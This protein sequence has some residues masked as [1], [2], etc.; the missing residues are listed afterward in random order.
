MVGIIELLEDFK[1]S[2]QYEKKLKRV[3]EKALL[4]PENLFI[5]VRL[6]DLLTKLRKKKE[7]VGLYE[8]AAQQFIQKNLFAHAIAL[9]KIIFRLEPPKDDGE[10]MTILTRLYEQMLIYR[11]TT[12]VA[13]EATPSQT[14]SSSP[15]PCETRR[16]GLQLEPKAMSPSAS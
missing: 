5:Q 10:K 3:Q 1:V 14:P 15:Q 12:S 2:W 13:E 9:K 6:A 7:A 16:G 11:E 4:H 8:L